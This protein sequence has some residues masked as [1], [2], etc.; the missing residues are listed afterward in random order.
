[1]PAIEDW[2]WKGGK[3]RGQLAN[4]QAQLLKMMND[5]M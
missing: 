5:K 2:A 4:I 1:V 3:F